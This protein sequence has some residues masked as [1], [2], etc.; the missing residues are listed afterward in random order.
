MLHANL[1][2][3]QLAGPDQPV[4]GFAVRNLAGKTA[5]VRARAYV[6]ALGG[7]ENPRILLH[8]N[9]LQPTGVGNQHDLV[10]RFFHD[11]LGLSIGLVMALDPAWL[12][13][14]QQFEHLLGTEIQQA[15]AVSDAMMQREQIGNIAITFGPVRH[16]R[17]DSKGYRALYSVKQELQSGRWPDRLG[18]SLWDILTDLGGIAEAMQER[19]S[20]VTQVY[21]QGEQV[22]DPDSRVLLDQERDALGLRR[23]ML[24]W[25]VSETDRRTQRAIGEAIVMELGRLDLARVQLADWMTADEVDWTPEIIPS[26]HH[27]GTTRMA[28]HA[29][30]GVVDSDC[31]TFAH[32]NLFIADSSVFPS[33]GFANPTLTIVALTLRLADHL[34]TWLETMPQR[35]LR[36]DAPGSGD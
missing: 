5:V 9:R 11:H 12:G 22:P 18:Q 3:I 36:A 24:D 4:A 16:A 28:D 26:N 2:D 6:L 29:S 8:S 19:F 1:T 14:Y 34:K 23:V 31:R 17:K 32:D 27:I 35:D 10:G 13:S 20:T 30:R 7:I 33:S 21:S 15:I 25:R